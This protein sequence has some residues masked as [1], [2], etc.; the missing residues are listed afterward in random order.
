MNHHKKKD[1]DEG[2]NKADGG[3]DFNRLKQTRNSK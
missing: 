1:T 3:D 2:Q